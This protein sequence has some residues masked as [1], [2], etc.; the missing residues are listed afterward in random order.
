MAGPRDYDLSNVPI[1]ASGQGLD[2]GCPG[3][4]PL[5][6]TAAAA[7]QTQ[8]FR[9]ARVSS[10]TPEGALEAPSDLESQYSRMRNTSARALMVIG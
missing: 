5:N 2:F 6:L 9:A 3:P 4:G 7:A 8:C 10:A 1:L